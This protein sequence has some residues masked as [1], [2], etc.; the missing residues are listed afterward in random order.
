MAIKITIDGPKRPNETTP[1]WQANAEVIEFFDGSGHTE[2][3]HAIRNLLIS[4]KPISDKL[5]PGT[6][7][8]LCCFQDVTLF[9]GGKKFKYEY[10]DDDERKAYQKA[11]QSVLLLQANPADWKSN[12]FPPCVCIAGEIDLTG[13]K[14]KDERW[15]NLFP[16]DLKPENIVVHSSGFSFRGQARVP[17]SE[18]GK[19]ID[20]LIWASPM[21]SPPTAAAAPIL[22]LKTDFEAMNADRQK[23]QK[24]F[25]EYQAGF[26]E[27]SEI[28]S[29]ELKFNEEDLEKV[30]QR[31]LTLDLINK[32]GIPEFHWEHNPLKPKEE[33]LKLKRGEVQVLLADQP[34][35]ERDVSARSLMT[36]N[37]EAVFTTNAAET[38][39]TVSFDDG[40]NASELNDQ[41]LF[42]YNL[43]YT[44]NKEP[45]ENVSLKDFKAEYDAIETATILRRQHSLPM[46]DASVGVVEPALLCGYMPLADGWAQL[47]V[48]NLTEQIVFDALQPETDSAGETEKDAKNPLLLGA[49]TFGN[50]APEVFQA[51]NG[52]SAW[53]ITLLD[54]SRYEG[55]IIFTKHSDKWIFTNADLKIFQ[56][57]IS[58]NG[59]L[60]LGVAPPTAADAL[61]NTDDW[62]KCFQQIS[63]RTSKANN[64]FPAPFVL[65]FKKVAFKNTF[66][67]D[68]TPQ[69]EVR[70]YSLPMLSE[71][72]FSYR[73]NTEKTETVPDK[74]VFEV[75]LLNGLWKTAETHDELKKDFWLN[76]P[77]VWRRHPRMPLIQALPLT[78]NQSPP[79]YPSQSRQLIPFELLVE[80]ENDL[81]LPKN[82]RF[83]M[84][85][86]DWANLHPASDFRIA[87]SWK[88][89]DCLWM[90][91]LGVPGLIFNPNEATELIKFETPDDLLK[92][93]PNTQYLYGLPY[94]DEINALAGLPKDEDEPRPGDEVAD[95][96]AEPM[97]R[98]R[99]AK[100]WQELSEKAILARQDA[101]EVLD[102]FYALDTKILFVK[103][104]AEPFIWQINEAKLNVNNYPGTLILNGKGGTMRL[105]GE[106]ALRGLDGKFKIVGNELEMA[107]AGDLQI[108]AGS[109]FALTDDKQARDQRG[110]VRG[111]TDNQTELFL[112][113]ELK[114]GDETVTL[115]SLKKSLELPVGGKKW[116]FWFR[117][118]PV[119]ATAFER[120]PSGDT[121][122]NDTTATSTEKVYL[123]GYEWRLNDENPKDK[124]ALKLFGFNFF[125]MTLEKVKFENNEVSSVELTGRLQLPEPSPEVHTGEKPEL[126]NVVRVVF[127]KQGDEP[128]KLTALKTA[129]PPDANMT[130][131]G[132]WILKK[133]ITDD[134]KYAPSLFWSD[135]ELVWDEL[136]LK[137][138]IKITNAE[139]EFF[140]FNELWTIKDVNLSFDIATGKAD[141]SRGFNEVL[142]AKL[143]VIHLHFEN[144]IPT[145]VGANLAFRWGG[146]NDLTA[147]AFVRV[148]LLEN[149]PEAKLTISA[150]FSNL[151]FDKKQLQST[152]V[153][154]AFQFSF[155]GLEMPTDIQLLPGMHLDKRKKISGLAT[156]SFSVDAAQTAPGKRLKFG[157]GFCE[158]IIPCRWGEFLQD[159]PRGK[160]LEDSPVFDS[161]AGIVYA[162]YTLESD[163]ES[164]WKTGL[165]LNGFVEIKNLI[166]FPRPSDDFA[167]TLGTVRFAY[168]QNDHI[169]A[170]DSRVLE[171]VAKKLK[172]NSNLKARIEG[173]ADIDGEYDFNLNL[174]KNRANFVKGKFVEELKKLGLTDAQIKARIKAV[175]GFSSGNPADTNE[176]VAGKQN[177]RRVEIV[178]DQILLPAAKPNTT[179]LNHLR[180]SLRVLFNQHELTAGLLT[181][182]N[183]PE[184]LLNFKSETAWQF[185]A[186]VEHQLADISQDQKSRIESERRWTVAQEV[187]FAHPDLL[188]KKLEQFDDLKTTHPAK[189]EAGTKK[190]DDVNFG[191]QR[192]EVIELLRRDGNQVK[193]LTETLI[194]EASAIHWILPEEIAENGFTNLQ[195]LP[196]LTQQALL[197]S[198]NDFAMAEIEPLKD[199][200]DATTRRLR[201][202]SLWLLLQMPFLGRLQ[203]KKHERKLPPITESVLRADPIWH[204]VELKKNNQLL[205]KLSLVL[206]SWANDTDFEIRISDFDYSRFR[207]WRRLDSATLEEAWFRLQNPPVETKEKSLKG[208]I[209]SLPPDSPGRLSR[210]ISLINAFNEYRQASPPQIVSETA[211]VGTND[212]V[213]RRDNLFVLQG[214]AGDGDDDINGDYG[215]HYVAAQI[216][217]SNLFT[218]GS[219]DTKRF[220]AATMIP[221]NLKVSDRD[222]PF[223]VSFAVSPYLGINKSLVNEKKNEEPFLV[224]AELLVLESN[225]KS[226]SIIA[227]RIFQENFELKK[228]GKETVEQLA[229]DSP[230]AVLRVRSIFNGIAEDQKS[231]VRIEY[232][233]VVLEHH[234]RKS[235]PTK[236]TRSLRVKVTELHFAEG[237]FGGFKLPENVRDFELAPP[238]VPVVKPLYFVNENNHFA[239]F[240]A[241]RFKIQSAKD[242]KGLVG[243]LKSDGE[244]RIW[245]NAASHHVQFAVPLGLL[246]EKFRA[247]SIHSLLP[248]VPNLPLPEAVNLD[249]E[250]TAETNDLKKWQ[251]ILPGSYNYLVVGGRAG[252]QFTFRHSLLTQ[253][254][255]KSD[256]NGV[257]GKSE[258]KTILASGGIPV[259]HRIPR[260]VLIPSSM[261][262]EDDIR[263]MQTWASRFDFIGKTLKASFNPADNAILLKGEREI[264]GFT[265]S[266]TGENLRFL[267]PNDD[268]KFAFQIKGQPAASAIENW[269]L[270][271]FLTAEGKK[272]VLKGEPIV[273]TKTEYELFFDDE[274]D[275][276]KRRDKLADFLKGL[277]DGA[278][279]AVEIK[280]EAKDT[281]IKG[282]KQ[283]LVF[284]LRYSIEGLPITA[285]RP[286]FIQFEDP[287]YNHRLASQTSQSSRTYQ[288]GSNPKKTVTLTLAADRREYNPTSEVNFAV[289]GED[290]LPA[291]L[292]K[293]SLKVQRL[294]KESG[295]IETLRKIDGFEVGK[296]NQINL[297]E[298]ASPPL[299]KGEAV[300]LFFELEIEGIKQQ[301]IAL[302]ADIVNLPVMPMPEAAYALLR[303]SDGKVECLRF[304]WSPAATRVELTNPDDLKTGLVRRRAVFRWTDTVRFELLPVSKNKYAVQK[305]MPV[306]A[307]HFPAF[308]DIEKN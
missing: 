89:A 195:Y 201:Q 117:D 271:F 165:L 98:E 275:D 157:S 112:K 166:S 4:N 211:Q 50:D 288:F 225:G 183:S 194:V 294:N 305:I 187:R 3:H 9:I 75:L 255:Q 149:S 286:V 146:K 159:A 31:W 79:N 77:L 80:K 101:D 274:R 113:T 241:I 114:R 291:E 169:I 127:A 141:F 14:I 106:K 11:Y 162:N 171:E 40:L 263:A 266:L 150:N 142:P 236:K 145:T 152:L 57:D 49:A 121:D 234:P 85:N 240:S 6:M 221:A 180:H 119:T 230:I 217:S 130:R 15:E 208:V 214:Y 256:E 213:W 118:L 56:P 17:W 212:L 191:Y 148:E 223:P 55:K 268:G 229:N 64:L 8:A 12:K 205:N 87:K 156:M 122:I 220:A 20:S 280:A 227:G 202:Q 260:P 174:S 198:P 167:G 129:F 5:L 63:L 69:K 42:D 182:V 224:Y 161:S 29:Q 216:Y 196:D 251:P 67:Q 76:L 283:T 45:Q 290:D 295:I 143:S 43:S 209:A 71:W 34:P 302:R 139:L 204:T 27:L 181:A 185:L 33:I 30:W 265:A 65:N 306:G 52:K 163:P 66:E 207:R 287:Q 267:M 131:K 237:Q 2:D 303:Q 184:L 82:W 144:F 18:K 175:I 126:G 239:D 23:W 252:A 258:T 22:R 245:W 116:Q 284:P 301:A 97:A 62:L 246:P 254:K 308:T 107:D 257:E 298:V 59:F 178:V 48:M 210:S 289:F 61:P 244:R 242:E 25:A 16:T 135:L 261:Q 279:V 110:L 58:L 297:S 120:L 177:N 203:H 193:K 273:S 300:V 222:N 173:H 102:K 37:I 103:H 281:T 272:A 94:T 36:V 108:E 68:E 99:F 78:Q 253:N 259:Q 70:Q 21:F 95:P 197:S 128:F 248:T 218:E 100:Y 276:A 151:K 96:P 140:L 158:A 88:E 155:N 115:Y 13:F 188:S 168:Q 46:P 219:K 285:L 170:E 123:T 154:G 81:S 262:A 91:S 73:A 190:I 232:N 39:M 243:S 277:P 74:S 160:A 186:I 111:L 226:L 137:E 235:L 84:K 51:R 278:N 179:K 104:L 138:K 26:Q 292:S 32:T 92:Q 53:N 124:T 136:E 10:K 1:L 304:A 60:W 35:G 147:D 189:H 86:D 133:S 172:N 132:E 269:D 134:P 19:R 192:K 105:E 206:S 299:Q 249:G 28:F 231:A 54:G 307:T 90:A 41:S 282:Y 270:S 238:L 153:D 125:P 47:P 264:S 247:R 293:G 233:F 228:W 296:L 200:A 109:M 38:E 93:L 7:V 72:D 250:V 164:G 83:E 199:L 176:T 44:P 215:F 24:S